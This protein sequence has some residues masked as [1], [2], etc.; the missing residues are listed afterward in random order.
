MEIQDVKFVTE[1]YISFISQPKHAVG[2]SLN[3]TV[4]LG[5]QNIC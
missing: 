1:I 2:I 4:L 3:K 5:T